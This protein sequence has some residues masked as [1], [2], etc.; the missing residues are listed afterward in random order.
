M[1]PGVYMDYLKILH[2]FFNIVVGLFFLY[3]GLLGWR[4]R[5][6]RK[7]AG[8]R[9]VGIIKRH[10]K[11]GPVLAVLG[12]AGYLAGAALVYLDKGHIVEYP[13]HL[14]AGSCIALLIMTT[15]VISRMIKGPESPWRTPH[16]V[17]GLFI[18]F[19]YLLQIYTG[20]DILL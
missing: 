4:I 16:F 9:N 5:K 13:A 7:A 11:R 2:G 8:Q 10:R 3:Q 1:I 17:I 18:L 20:L 15:F 19:L 6:E 12:V 14:I